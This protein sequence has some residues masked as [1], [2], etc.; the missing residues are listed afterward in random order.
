MHVILICAHLCGWT[1]LYWDFREQ[2]FCPRFYMDHKRVSLFLLLPHCP[3]PSYWYSTTNKIHLNCHRLFWTA[4]LLSV[5]ALR[6][7][8]LQDLLRVMTMFLLYILDWKLSIQQLAHSYPSICIR[9]YESIFHSIPEAKVHSLPFNNNS[10]FQVE[11]MSFYALG[12][13]KVNF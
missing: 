4:K 5:L 11:G 2:T 10:L 9:Y 8:I 12:Y 3:A 13:Q 6:R 1:T 7:K